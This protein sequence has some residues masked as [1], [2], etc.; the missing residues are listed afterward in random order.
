M[1][2]HSSVLAWR[3][4]GTGEPSGLPSMGSHRVGHD[5]SDAAAAAYTHTH[6]HTHIYIYTFF[7]FGQGG[8]FVF[9]CRERKTIKLDFVKDCLYNISFLGLEW[10][11]HESSKVFL[12]IHSLVLKGATWGQS[13]VWKVH[14][15]QRTFMTIPEKWLFIQEFK[16]NGFSSPILPQLTIIDDSYPC[17]KIFSYWK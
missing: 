16:Q 4:P 13:E 11:S 7:F 8:C 3:I 10:R 15:Y 14:A 9:L 2:T 6:T 5:W 17:Q 1:A 12:L